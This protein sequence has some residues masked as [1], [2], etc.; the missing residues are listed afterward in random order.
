MSPRA[1]HRV[2]IECVSA[3]ILVKHAGDFAADDAADRA[4]R[5]WERLDILAPLYELSDEPLPDIGAFPEW[6]E[7]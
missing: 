6:P 4:Q 5:L 1:R 3:M 2:F 7:G